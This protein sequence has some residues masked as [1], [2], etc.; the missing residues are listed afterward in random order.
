MDNQRY[1][2]RVVV[3]LYS[4]TFDVF[5]MGVMC[6]SITMFPNHQGCFQG[7]VGDAKIGLYGALKKI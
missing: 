5:G 6:L 4:L 7:S 3:T 2:H 1:E